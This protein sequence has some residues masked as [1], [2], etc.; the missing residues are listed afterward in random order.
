MLV[1]KLTALIMVASAITMS[2]CNDNN[3]QSPPILTTPAP[4]VTVGSFA[5]EQ[6]KTLSCN[7]NNPTGINA[8]T[9]TENETAVDVEALTRGCMG[10]PAS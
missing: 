10:G 3:P 2:G 6:V 7:N 9:F 1:K 5:T 4:A 8:T